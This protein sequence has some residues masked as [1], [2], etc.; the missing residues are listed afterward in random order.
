MVNTL[1]DEDKKK[2]IIDKVEES[3]DGP[4]YSTVREVMLKE[5]SDQ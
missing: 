1:E 2:A 3:E 4:T 5:I